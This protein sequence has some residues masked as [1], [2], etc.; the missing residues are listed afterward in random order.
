MDKESRINYLVNR[1]LWGENTLAFV[2]FALMTLLPVFETV[3]EITYIILVAEY[4]NQIYFTR[5]I[6]HQ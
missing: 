3:T 1:L 4:K 2:I 6:I 5:L